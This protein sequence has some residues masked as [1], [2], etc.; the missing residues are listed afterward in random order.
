MSIIESISREYKYQKEW[1]RTEVEH[2]QHRGKSKIGELADGAC[3]S[4]YINKFMIN[5]YYKR[6]MMEM[7]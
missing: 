2:H 7:K 6:K 4:L 1:T 3:L 5:S